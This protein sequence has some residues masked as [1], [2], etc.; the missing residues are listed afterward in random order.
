MD[1]KSKVKKEI[2]GPLGAPPRKGGLK[3]APKVPVKKAA[4]VVPKKE[5]VEDSKD[6]TVD[7][8]L[9]MKLKASQVTDPFARRVK[10]E[11]NPKSR[12]Q[13]AFGQGNTS[14]ARSFL[15]PK[16]SSDEAKLPK[17]YAE[18]WDYTHTDCPVALPLR[19]PYSGNPEILDEEEFG[20]SSASRAQDAESTAAEELELM[21]RSDESQLLLVQLPCSLPLP[22]QPQSVTEPNKGSEERRE[23]MRPSS[24]RGSK[25]K[26]LPAGY[27]GKILVYRSGKVKMK[28]G[29]TLFDVSSGSN[30]KFVQ[31][32]A[33][34]NTKEKHCC[35]VGE[36]SKRAVI[37]PDIGC[38][39]GSANKME[40]YPFI[41][42]A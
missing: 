8:E 40:E 1:D 12:T 20:E 27:M 26:D 23:G 13:V 30:C 22:M 37:T 4:K 33:A 32:V 19:R 10:T 35:T 24:Q 34:I 29:D 16:S 7:K 21:D 15:I 3:F 11:E 42:F 14:Y 5:P 39:L 18:P 17:E 25:L 6:E 9:L 31:E 28:I 2:N 41:S 36:I 38:L